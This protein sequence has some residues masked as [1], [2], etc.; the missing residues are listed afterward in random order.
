MELTLSRLCS[1][2]RASKH[3]PPT[4]LKENTRARARQ[5]FCSASGPKCSAVLQ[6]STPLY[7]QTTA[8]VVC[9]V[10]VQLRA[11][12]R[13]INLSKT[14]EFWSQN[15]L[16]W[17]RHSAGRPL[18]ITATLGRRHEQAETA[19]LCDALAIVRCLQQYCY[20][21]RNS[22]INVALTLLH[23]HTNSGTSASYVRLLPRAT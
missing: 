13:L 6:T 21:T 14:S 19:R 23:E 15:V 22:E 18:V 12:H 4:R 1:T 11:L 7:S 5:H 3:G 9:D 8:C 20:N 17:L 2:C 16:S 10:V